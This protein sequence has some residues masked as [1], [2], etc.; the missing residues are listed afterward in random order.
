[1]TDIWT[2]TTEFRWARRPYVPRPAS[3]WWERPNPPSHAGFRLEQKW[4]VPNGI[5]Q[6]RP[7]P[8]ADPEEDIELFMPVV[9]S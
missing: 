9:I 7:I 8:L 1:M 2:A 3:R 6:W 5:E 4:T